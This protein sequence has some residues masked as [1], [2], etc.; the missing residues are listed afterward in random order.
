MR[1]RYARS[2]GQQSEAANGRSWPTTYALVDLSQCPEWSMMSKCIK[3][4]VT[5]KQLNQLFVGHASLS[6]SSDPN[7]FSLFI[8]GIIIN[9]STDTLEIATK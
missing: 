8:S 1:V 5:M 7:T 9:S 2:E 3:L 4:V 6:C